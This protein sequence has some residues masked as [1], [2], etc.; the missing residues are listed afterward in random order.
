MYLLLRDRDRAWAGEGQRERE[1]QNVKQAPGSELSAQSPMWGLNSRAV[2]SWPEL[3]SDAQPTEP[4]RCPHLY[5]FQ[6]ETPCSVALVKINRDPSV[7][8]SLFKLF[9]F[10]LF[11]SNFLSLWTSWKWL[12]SRK[13][14]KSV[15]LWPKVSQ[16]TGS[17]VSLSASSYFNRLFPSFKNLKISESLFSTYCGF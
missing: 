11:L 10:A 7:A 13:I 1:T 4:P 17:W 3:K 14:L 2:R 12:K 6:L 16:H 9:H 5:H 15:E 8:N